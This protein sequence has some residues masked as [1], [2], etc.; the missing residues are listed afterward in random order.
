MLL[1]VLSKHFSAHGALLPALHAVFYCQPVHII[2]NIEYRE[3]QQGGF[4]SERLAAELLAATTL[5]SA[6][7]RAL[8]L[9]TC[10]SKSE[11]H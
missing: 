7:S 3:E 11:P 8:S 5:Q 2:C 9:L 1:K 10:M 4:V 6:G